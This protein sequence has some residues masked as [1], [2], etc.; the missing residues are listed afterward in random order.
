MLYATDG[1]EEA[2]QTA[3]ATER[4]AEIVKQLKSTGKKRITLADLARNL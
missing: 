2:P 3:D 1:T 4:T